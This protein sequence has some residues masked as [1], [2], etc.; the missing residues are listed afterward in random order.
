MATKT[1]N[2]KLTLE[3]NLTAIARANLEKI[4]QLGAVLPLDN[5]STVNLRSK[6][7]I[8]LRPEDP[9]IGGSGTG[10]TVQMGTASQLLTKLDIHAT[11]IDF[12]SATFE[13]SFTI[14][15][16]NVSKTGASVNDFSDFDT[17]VSG[18]SDVSA[19]S[20]HR[21]STS[22]PHSTT[23]AQVGAY[24]TSQV[25]TLL[26]AKADS[27]SLTSHTSASSGVHGVSGSVVGTTDTQTLSNKTINANSNTIENLANSNISSGAS[28]AYSKLALSGS[29]QASDLSSGFI[30]PW[31]KLSKTG[32][33]LADIPSRSH[34]D[35]QD[36]GSNTHAQ[37]DTHIA[38]STAHGTVSAVVGI[39]DTQTLTNKTIS[40]S[41]NTLS[42]ISNSSISASAAIAGSKIDPDFGN[43]EVKTLDGIVWEEGGFTTKLQA[44][45]AGQTANITLEL[46]P[47]TGSNGQV[48]TTNGSGGMTWTTVAGVGASDL[49][50][51]WS[52]ADGTS[53]TVTHSFGT[54]NVIIQVIDVNDSYRNISVDITRPTDNTAVLTSSEAPATSWEVLVYKV[55]N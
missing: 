5:T 38:A 17:E 4:D 39:S 8:I 27:T 16:A 35:L 53:K 12:N 55:A 15:W 9:S 41:S 42:D 44:A 23:A 31:A 50:A 20:S 43:Q 36:I 6:V 19:N 47:N 22:N 34:T 52:N 14:P 24:T 18:N 7:D 3:D 32:A 11:S 54:R 29:L 40:A 28:I 51:T 1:R 45:Q 49:S 2:L 33:D 30:L 46:P 10:G 25:D 37:I 21:T 26:A 48:L 13:G